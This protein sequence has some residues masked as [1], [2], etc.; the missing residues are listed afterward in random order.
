MFVIVLIVFFFFIVGLFLIDF[1]RVFVDDL[2][3]FF[4]LF[5]LLLFIFLSF[6]RFFWLLLFVVCKIDVSWD[7]VL[8]L[9]F[10]KFL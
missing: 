10:F 2:K 9:K 4:M 3:R 7:W 5:L 1:L 6:F 8:D